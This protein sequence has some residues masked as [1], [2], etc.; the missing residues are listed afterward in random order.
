MVIS[1][2]I[3]V[4]Y[5]SCKTPPP[6]VPEKPAYYSPIEIEPLTL[7]STIA[8]PTFENG[9]IDQLENVEL[10]PIVDKL[11]SQFERVFN[12]NGRFNVLERSKILGFENE[13]KSSNKPLIDLLQDEDLILYVLLIEW[14]KENLKFGLGAYLVVRD[15]GQVIDRLEV[16]INYNHNKGS[17]EFDDN[18]IFK[19]T[20]DIAKKYPR[21]NG[22]IISRDGISLCI[23]LANK[24]KTFVG[25]KAIV[26]N[27]YS[28]L[29][30]KLVS[31]DHS[32]TPVAE[33]KITGSRDNCLLGEVISGNENQVK[34][35]DILILK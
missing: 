19:L 12:E 9:I 25:Q 6:P 11:T 30:P 1:I 32:F 2:S 3:A 4:F 28:T 15:T 24:D 27:R 35:G 8:I 33:V 29:D 20:L 13:R 31:S 5:C 16:D 22:K 18:Q 21:L 10:Q 14:D 34:P 23:G 7:K 26:Y 17:I